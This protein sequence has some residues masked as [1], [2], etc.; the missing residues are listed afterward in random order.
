[1]LDAIL[2]V[3]SKGIITFFNK[4]AEDIWGYSKED[5]IGQNVSKLFSK[6]TI[7]TDDFVS[8]LVDINKDTYVS[9]RQE[10]NILNKWEEESSVLILVS[11]A[12]LNGEKTY[13]AFVQNIEMELF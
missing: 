13:T 10:V 12:D 9:V 4:A 2:S 8:N 6:E 1:M 5:L 3:N 11:E 7:E